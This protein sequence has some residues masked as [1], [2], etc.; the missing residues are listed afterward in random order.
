MVVSKSANPLNSKFAALMKQMMFKHNMTDEQVF[1][2][3]LN[4]SL[5]LNIASLQDFAQLQESVKQMIV[6][7]LEEWVNN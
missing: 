2:D 1:Y 6:S 5:N 3:Q 7:S 4:Q